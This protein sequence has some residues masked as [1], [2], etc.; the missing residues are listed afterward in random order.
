MVTVATG[1]K[2]FQ[3]ITLTYSG[4]TGLGTT[5]QQRIF[6]P[7][8]SAMGTTFAPN[9][10]NVLFFD[11]NGVVIPSWLETVGGVGSGGTTAIYWLKLNGFSGSTTVYIGSGVKEN[12]FWSAQGS[13]GVNYLLNGLNGTE[14]NGT[15]IFNYYVNFTAKVI[16][17][18]W[19]A[20]FIY[21]PSYSSTGGINISSLGGWQGYVTGYTTKVPEVLEYYFNSGT[22]QYAT[23]GI[24]TERHGGLNSLP[25]DLVD[26]SYNIPVGNFAPKTLNSQQVGHIQFQYRQGDYFGQWGIDVSTGGE[27]TLG[28]YSFS[29]R[30]YLVSGYILKNECRLEVN[31]GNVN[32][33]S[34]STRQTTGLPYL[35]YPIAGFTGWFSFGTFAGSNVV[36]KFVRTRDFVDSMPTATFGAMAEYTGVTSYSMNITDTVGVTD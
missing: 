7:L 14:D 2:W 18:T 34:Q 26:N 36:F 24:V 6:Y 4:S 20:M 35:K 33:V 32:M 15:A 16:P 1:V 27:P 31:Y 3:P 13:T 17:S 25:V 21:K 22:N 23:I 10:Q 11:E 9:R 30:D 19:L 28:G 29:F 5:Y 8:N 12:N